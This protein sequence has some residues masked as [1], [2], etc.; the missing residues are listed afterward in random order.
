MSADN[1]IICWFRNDLRLSDNPALTHAAQ[2]EKPVIALYIHDELTPDVRPM[3]AAQKWWLHKGLSDLADNLKALNCPLILRSGAAADII[4]EVVEETGA[5]SICWN[6]R[7]SNAEQQADRDIKAWMKE[8]GHEAISFC[9]IIMHEPEKVQTGSGKP[10]RVY[11]PFWKNLSENMLVREPLPTPESLKNFSK[12]ISSDRLDDWR[13]LPTKPDWSAGIS[14]AWG[15]GENAAWKRLNAFTCDDLQDYDTARDQP[16]PDRTSRMSPYLRHGH[17]SPHQLWHACQD[18]GRKAN[19]Q[20]RTVWMK[21]LVWREF[22][23]HLLHHNPQLHEKNFNEKFN[24]FSWRHSEK[25][26]KAW[27]KGQTGYPIVDAGMRQLWQTGWMHNRVRM[28]AASFLVKHLLIDWREGEAWFW[29]TLVDGD[30]ASNA[31]QWQWVAGTGADAAPFFRI[32]NPILQA[33]KFDA[34]GEY[35]KRYVPELA[36]LPAKYLGAPWEAP[37][38]VLEMA[39]VE[40]GKTYPRPIVDHK[41]ARQRALDTLAQVSGKTS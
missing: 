20:A 23:Y 10:Y 40:L 7:Y 32:F 33:G 2:S 9:G 31:A 28:I 4:R 34:K 12:E 3:G 30:P 39:G 22:S 36:K 41:E 11:T 26:L 37:K 19:A 35:I 8:Q 27:Q 18:V 5:D 14:E 17:I 15:V 24:G 29:D 1:P 6:R 16:A 13:L 21:E 25:D 38:N